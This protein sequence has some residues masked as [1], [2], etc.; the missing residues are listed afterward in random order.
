MWASST[1]GGLRGN[2][3]VQDFSVRRT[4]MPPLSPSN[5]HVRC[6]RLASLAQP[7]SEENEVTASGRHG[8]SASGSQQGILYQ[9]CECTRGSRAWDHLSNTCV[10]WHSPLCV[11]TCTALLAVDFSPSLN[12]P[13]PAPAWI[14]LTPR[15]M[16]QAHAGPCFIQGARLDEF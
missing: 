10:S 9:P 12:S 7:R 11:C 13:L 2:S 1:Q 3:D 5:D 14:A 6:R 15:C 8:H 16:S 4:P